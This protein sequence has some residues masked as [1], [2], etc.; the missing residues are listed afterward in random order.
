MINCKHFQIAKDLE[1]DIRTIEKSTPSNRLPIVT[2]SVN[3]ILTEMPP[4][5]Q[6]PPVIR[7]D[8]KLP[9]AQI[10]IKKYYGRKRD[11]Q[12]S[13]SEAEL[14]YEEHESTGKLKYDL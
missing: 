7:E 4:T 9:E 8:P 11:S 6:E 2:A 12:S 3:P 14:S 10:P 5:L 1:T 13:S